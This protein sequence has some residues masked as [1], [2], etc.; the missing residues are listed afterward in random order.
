M[1]VIR[2]T[3]KD[4]DAGKPF[5]AGWRPVKI[6]GEQDKLTKAKD[7]INHIITLEVTLDGNEVREFEHNFSDKA[8]GFA[9]DFI[10][11][12]L[13]KDPEIGIDYDLSKFVGL[14]LFAE[15]SKEIYKDAKNPNDRGRPV[16]KI[17]GWASKDNPPF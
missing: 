8:P 13:G 4:L 2:F 5:E 15:F 16:N 7:S 3:Q 6:L 11:I 17:V 12:C 1:G 14:E 10:G 9:R